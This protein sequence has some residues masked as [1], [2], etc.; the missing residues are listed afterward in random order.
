[1]DEVASLRVLYEKLALAVTSLVQFVRTGLANAGI[2]LQPA[3]TPV[4]TDQRY[5]IFVY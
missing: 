1:M 4:S 3:F 2:S 5:A